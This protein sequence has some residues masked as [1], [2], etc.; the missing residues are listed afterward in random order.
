MDRVAIVTG[1]SGGM[2]RATAIRA[3]PLLSASRLR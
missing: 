3:V 1:A 2:A